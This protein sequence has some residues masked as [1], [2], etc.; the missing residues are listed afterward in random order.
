MRSRSTN[1]LFA[2]L[3]L[4]TA[5]TAQGTTFQTELTKEL[6]KHAFFKDVSFDV[7]ADRVPFLFYLQSSLRRDEKDYEYLVINPILPFLKELVDRFDAIYCK[8]QGIVMR[9][10]MGQ[11]AIAV[12]ASRG[13][14]DDYARATQD[15]SLHM[16][17]AHYNQKLR[18]AVTYR[19]GFGAGDPREERHS[20]LHE[21]VHALQH[22]YSSTGQ[23]TKPVWFNEGL[24][25]YL[26]SCDH[27]PESLR[28]PPLLP[29]HVDAM[30]Y[31]HGNQEGRKLLLP[32]VDLV[33]PETYGQVVELIRKRA[34]S[35]VG[36]QPALG[37]FYAQSEMMVRFL[38]EG[39]KGKYRDGVL[40]Y[41]KAVEAGAAG[42]AAFQEAFGTKTPESMAAMDREWQAWIGVVLARHLG[43]DVDPATGKGL[44][45]AALP[46]PVAFDRTTLAWRS[47]EFEQRLAAA[48]RACSL[49]EY[50]RALAMLPGQAD[51]PEAALLRR[52]TKRVQALVDLRQRVVADLEQRGAVDLAGK[53]GKFVRRDANDVVVLVKQTETRVRL[54]PSV[55]LAAGSKLKAFETTQSWLEAWLRWLRGERRASLA[56]LLERK[57][58]QMETLRTDLTADLDAEYGVAAFAL[59]RLQSEALPEDHQGARTALVEL[60]KVT[61]TNN[62]LFV[63]RKAA[64]EQLARALAERA[65]ALDDAEALGIHATLQPQA[66]GRVR[67]EYKDPRA[68]PSADFSH[69][70]DED[71]R[72]AKRPGIAYDGPTC[73]QPLDDH[74]GA[75]GSGFLRWAMPLVGPHEIEF[76]YQISGENSSISVIFCRAP[77]RHIQATADGRLLIDDQTRGIKDSAG[78]TTGVTI[79]EPHRLRIVHDGAKQASVH[80]DGSSRAQLQSVGNCIDGEFLL[81]VRSSTPIHIRKLTITG[82][83]D[84]ANPAAIRERYVQQ[85]LS[86]L[87]R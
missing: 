34:G 31:A 7:E 2:A 26:S 50:D 17:L 38:H 35:M 5:A 84:P 30:I 70:P 59:D 4:A 13:L 42:L 61:S 16:T 18:L 87:W 46:P 82:K 14:Y 44:E 20:L 81:A 6:Q 62:E 63:R 41:F 52:E 49:G 48:R 67:I 69:A 25:E 43:F 79:G 75:I 77:G 58:S 32:I 1:G 19:A 73:V 71:L 3:A 21:V 27:M 23:M 15:A 78:S 10:G 85:A 72:F 76:E 68:A 53:R 80:L 54:D 60:V 12:L 74:W 28:A 45:R 9:D 51:G 57:Y 33:V 66:D 36:E 64:V 11:Y 55:L 22:A 56:S 83:L 39:E 86:R 37:M 24:A 40:R 65:F 47:D 8:P 29:D